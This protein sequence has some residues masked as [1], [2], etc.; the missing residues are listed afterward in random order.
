MYKH[1]GYFAKNWSTSIEDT[2][3]TQS[4]HC[5]SS[6]CGTVGLDSLRW[7]HRNQTE[8]LPHNWGRS[9]RNCSNY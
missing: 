2:D 8:L 7:K 5:M 4:C 6:A 9:F 1:I 3:I